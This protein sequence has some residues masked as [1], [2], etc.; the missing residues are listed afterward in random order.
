MQHNEEPPQ[1]ADLVALSEQNSKTQQE[2]RQKQMDAENR[3]VRR[4]QSFKVEHS[5]NEE[6][7]KADIADSNAQAAEQNRKAADEANNKH[8]AVLSAEQTQKTSTKNFNEMKIKQKSQQDEQTAKGEA[9][10]KT[11]AQAA[12]EQQSKSEQLQKANVELNQKAAAES[13]TKANEQSQKKQQQAEQQQKTTQEQQAK[14]KYI[15]TVGPIQPTRSFKLRLQ[16]AIAVVPQWAYMFWIKPLATTSDWASIL[17]HG[18]TDSDR[19]PSVLFYPGSSRLHIRS[20]SKENWNG[21]FDPSNPL[22]MQ[23]WSHIALVHTQ[24][25]FSVYLNGV[26]LG[27]DNNSGPLQKA[28]D[29]YCSSPWYAAAQ[30]QLADIRYFDRFVTPQEV[31]QVQAANKHP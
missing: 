26:S 18:N 24:A 25:G 11:M 14:S 20:G 3:D 1:K 5:L 17:H 29:L 30:A 10:T 13:Q 4:E 27:Q 6:D 16:S 8:T 9:G 15:L 23:A 19:N 28:G 2:H 31:Q 22:P 21:G 7:T 12:A